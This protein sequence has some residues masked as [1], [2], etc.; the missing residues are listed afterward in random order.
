MAVIDVNRLL[1][2][3]TDIAPCGENLEYDAAFGELERVAKGKEERRSGTEVIP[4]EEPKWPEVGEAADGLLERTRDLRVLAY[5]THAALNVDGFAGLAAGLQVM[6]GWVQTFWDTVYPQLDKEDDNDPTLRI[7]SLA[8]LDSR[9]GILRTLTRVPLVASRAAGRYSLRDIRLAK[10]EVAPAAGEKK[11][12]SALI[13]AAFADC[14]VAQLGATADAVREASK[15]LE[16]IVAVVRER[17][18]AARAPTLANLTK[19]LRALQVLLTQQLEKRGV[20]AAAAPGADGAAQAQGPP[21]P[22]P[23][24]IRTR[25]DAI[26]ILDDVSDFFRKNEPSSP[27]PLLLQRAKRL[28]SKDFM[29]ILKDLTPNAVSQAEA[30]GGLEKGKG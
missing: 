18:G 14:D 1:Q 3:I 25:E 21:P 11:P 16:A 20:A 6:H 5:L 4:A 2:P 9:E 7:N 17:V 30:I 26:R 13:D 12:D 15:T 8:A 27:V 22:P 23:G 24:G 28:V 10:G 29:E 19:D